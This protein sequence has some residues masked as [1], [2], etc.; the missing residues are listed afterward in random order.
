MSTELNLEEEVK[1]LFCDTRL[2]EH[3]QYHESSLCSC[4]ADNDGQFDP[5]DSCIGGFR[6][7]DPVEYN[8]IRTQVSMREPMDDP[9]KIPQGSNLYEVP[10]TAIKQ[11][12]QAI[13]VVD[14]SG[15]VD[16]STNANIKINI[17]DGTAVTIDCSNSAADTSAVTIDEIVREINAAGFGVIAYEGGADGDSALPGFLVLRSLVVSD[18][19][20]IDI[21]KPATGDATNTILGYN[22]A[23]YP[24]TF[25]NTGT[26]D[27]VLPV[28]YSVSV[29]DVFVVE[30]RKIRKREI[31]KRGTQDSLH[32]F[33]MDRVFSISVRGTFYLEGVDF[34]TS[35][36]DITWNA[37][38]GPD[39]DDNYAVEYEGDAE[40]IAFETAPADR[41]NKNE[42]LPKKATVALRNFIES[43]EIPMDS[44]TFNPDAN[45]S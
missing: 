37:G 27:I 24:F 39:T 26:T 19:S 21:L 15:D 20:R 10:H 42:L 11:F 28:Y 31:L 6:Y 30:N 16:L 25:V 4:W 3:V 17:D 23:M 33:S 34:T 43:D 12:A 8:L 2:S 9:G 5:A 13:G 22:P 44:V 45:F 40:Y 35:G 1:E 18:D 38:K 14:I 7:K 29:G 41:G 32:A 36:V